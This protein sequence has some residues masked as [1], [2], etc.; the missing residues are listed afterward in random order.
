MKESSEGIVWKIKLSRSQ[1]VVVRTSTSVSSPPASSVCSL[2]L[3]NDFVRSYSVW[4]LLTTYTL[5]WLVFYS[6]LRFGRFFMGKNVE[7]GGKYLTLYEYTFCWWFSSLFSCIFF[8]L[9]A[10]SVWFWFFFHPDSLRF[11]PL[12]LLLQEYIVFQES[13]K[14][15]L[16]LLCIQESFSLLVSSMRHR[17]DDEFTDNRIK[18]PTQDKRRWGRRAINNHREESEAE[19][20]EITCL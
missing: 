14:Q 11:P 20:K 7:G 2:F 10:K 13:V 4:C 18:S 16:I 9:D 17:F 8:R 3:M 12:P 5:Q 15:D 19:R 1:V 6:S